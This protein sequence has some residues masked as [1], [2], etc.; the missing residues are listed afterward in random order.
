MECWKAIQ[1]YWRIA[2]WSDNQ[3]L[4]LI[5]LRKCRLTQKLGVAL[6]GQSAQDDLPLQSLR[7]NSQVYDFCISLLYPQ[8]GQGQKDVVFSDLYPVVVLWYVS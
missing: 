5:E 6:F 8:A 2:Y 4:I 1:P 3:V 7:Y